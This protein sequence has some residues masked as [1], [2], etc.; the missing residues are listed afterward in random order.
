[1]TLEAE[2]RQ[3][4]SDLCDA[5]RAKI[6]VRSI[7]LF[8]SLARGDATKSSDID[9]IVVSDDFPERYGARF[10]VLRPLF[11]EMKKT[12]AYRE[13]RK[14]GYWITFSPVPYR[15]EDLRDTPP[16]LLDVVE[17]GILLFDDGTMKRKLDEVREKLK[18]LGAR[19]VWTKRGSW[20][21]I[22]KPDMKPGEVVEI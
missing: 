1:M 21:W 5:I 20:Y 15:P 13:L 2:F 18:E 11:M 12:P 6:S 10:D 19:R 17:D 8:G 3:L 16:L 4:L 9:L 7:V 14:K 22:L